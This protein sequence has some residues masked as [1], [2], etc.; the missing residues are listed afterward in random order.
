MASLLFFDDVRLNRLENVVRHIGRPRPICESI[1]RDPEFETAWGYP[2]VF[3]DGHVD[4]QLAYSLNGWHF[5]RTLREPF[6]PNREPGEPDAGCV[7][8]SSWVFREGGDIDIYASACTHEHGY[9]PKGSGSIAAY[10]LRCDGWVYLESAGGVGLVGTRAVFWRAGEVELNVQS[11]GG[12]V[13]ARVTDPTGKPIEGYT[14]VDCQPFAGDSTAWT[15]QWGG[16]KELAALADRCV[17]IEVQLNRARLY[18]IRGD[19]LPLR[20]GDVYRYEQDGIEPKP[21]P[22]F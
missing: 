16:G 10:R 14:F 2:S 8:P 3:F 13:R 5:Q 18:A 15:P 20:A 11:P 1:F 6:I 22:G 21:R 12:D 19:F 7:Y 4:C 17:R 9:I